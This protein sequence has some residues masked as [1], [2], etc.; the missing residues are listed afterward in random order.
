MYSYKAESR[1]SRQRLRRIQAVGQHPS[2]PGSANF[3][4]ECL[5]FELV[6]VKTRPYDF[7]GPG[8]AQAEE[9]PSFP[10]IP[11]DRREL[12]VASHTAVQVSFRILFFLARR[13]WFGVILLC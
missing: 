3:L 10:S 1:E 11:C 7:C 5:T 4:A 6:L 9:Y 2:W 13:H 8:L 12:V